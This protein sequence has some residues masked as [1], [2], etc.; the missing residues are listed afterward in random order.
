MGGMVTLCSP[1]LF[2]LNT[3][4]LLLHLK[5]LD[6][7]PEARKVASYTQPACTSFVI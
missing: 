5:A 6:K 1:Q 7:R 3:R 2:K 4:I